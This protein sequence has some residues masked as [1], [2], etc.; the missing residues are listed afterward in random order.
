MLCGG[1]LKLNLLC[2]QTNNKIK[3]FANLVFQNNPVT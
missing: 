1:S 2:D 3:G